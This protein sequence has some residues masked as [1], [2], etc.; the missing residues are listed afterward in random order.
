MNKLTLAFDSVLCY[1]RIMD[2]LPSELLPL[3]QACELLRRARRPRDVQ[4][5][6]DRIRRGTLRGVRLGHYWYVF[7]GDI[8]R[9]ARQTYHSKGGRPHSVTDSSTQYAEGRLAVDINEVLRMGT[10]PIETRFSSMLGAQAFMF[11][12]KRGQLEKQYPKLSQRDL[13]LKMFEVLSNG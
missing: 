2:T 11:G 9:L 5:L 12:I 6:R 13:V 1:T 3:S 7:R 4:S 8:E 10:L